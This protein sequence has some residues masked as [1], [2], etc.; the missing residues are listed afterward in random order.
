MPSF[1][2]AISKIINKCFETY[3]YID[4]VGESILTPLQKPGKPLGP[5]YIGGVKLFPL[6]RESEE[7]DGHYLVMFCAW[8]MTMTL[9]LFSLRGSSLMR[10][11]SI[12]IEED[13]VDLVLRCGRRMPGRTGSASTYK[14]LGG[15]YSLGHVTCY[16]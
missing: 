2:G 14:R 7:L 13:E 10:Q 1:C 11:N 6:P 4:A 3:S 15:I 8:T 9:L 16:M 5:G 12:A